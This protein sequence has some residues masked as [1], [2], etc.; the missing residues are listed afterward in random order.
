MRIVTKIKSKVDNNTKKFDP[1]KT[2]ILLL[3]LL[4]DLRKR[5]RKLENY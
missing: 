2:S 5:K 1:F 4:Y 3:L